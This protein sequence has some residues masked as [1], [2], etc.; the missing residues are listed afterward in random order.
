MKTL[1]NRLYRVSVLALLTGILALSG[2]QTAGSDP[3]DRQVDMRGTYDKVL[4]G[5][6]NRLPPSPDAKRDRSAQESE[7]RD[8]TNSIN[9]DVSLGSGRFVNPGVNIAGARENTLTG[10]VD[11]AFDRAPVSQV[12]EAVVGK[13]MGANFIID[14]G[15]AGNVTLKTARPVDKSSVR[16]LLEQALSLSNIAMIRTAPGQY[17]IVPG[18]ASGRFTNV[19]L[20]AGSDGSGNLVILPLDHIS[21][22]EMTKVLAPFT[23]QGAR[24]QPDEAREL[25]IISGDPAQIDTILETAQMFDVD[26][27]AQMSFGIFEAKY[28][29]PESL[30]AE[31]SKV[32]GGAEGVIGSQVEFVP[33]PRLNSVLVIAKRPGRI[34]QAESWIRRLDVNIGGEGRRYKFL[35]VLSAD[36]EDIAGTLSDIFSE[37]SRGSQRGASSGFGDG[38]PDGIASVPGSN[39]QGRA[40]GDGPKIRADAATNALIVYG[41]DDEVRQIGELLSR[42]D[43]LPDQV[44]IEAVIAEVTLNDDLRYGVQWFFDTRDGGNLTFSDA[45]SGGVSAR[46]PGFAYTFSDNYVQAALSALS[47]VTEIEIVSSPQIVTQDNQTATLQVGDQVPVITQSAVSVENPS[48]PI[49]NSI[50]YRDTGILLTVTPRIND[51]DIVV[52]EV[53]QEVSDA[54]PTTVGGIDTSAIQQRQ[55]DSVVNIADGETLALGGLIRSSKSGGKSGIPYLK[56]V[57]LV[58]NAFSSNSDNRTRTELVIFMTPHIIRSQDDAR[59]VSDHLR[60]KLIG[61]KRSGFLVNDGDRIGE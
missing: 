47:A 24:I 32:F 10:K 25:L 56:D 54:V 46:F 16:G 60:N 55:F 8:I 28:V 19:P 36:A 43:V 38:R 40:G 5:D 4:D 20:L 6:G 18:S 11:L 45:G 3:F 21:A 14:P 42:L 7:R 57:P 48:A 34:A 2:C 44:M 59:R 13:I 26:W 37:Q 22:K 1:L 9:Q 27:L 52:L 17:S 31:L 33:M 58:G 49:V 35:P 15:V 61:L 41:T 29:D 39:S 51:G 12:I 30:V 50:Q 53:S 23:P